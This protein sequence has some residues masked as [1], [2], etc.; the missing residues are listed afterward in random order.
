MQFSELYRACRSAFIVS[1]D[2]ALRTQL[3]EFI[4]HQLIKWKKDTDVL[5]IPIA[6]SVLLQFQNEIN[7]VEE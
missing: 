2:L 6:N 3:T 1:S 4:D 7:E 5:S